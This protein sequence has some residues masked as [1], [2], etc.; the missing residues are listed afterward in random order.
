M[1]IIKFVDD[2]ASQR[3]FWCVDKSSHRTDFQ[4]WKIEKIHKRGKKKGLTAFFLKKLGFGHIIDHTPIFF[5]GNVYKHDILSY[6][7]FFEV[8]QRWKYNFCLKNL[9]WPL[10]F[11]F[12]VKFS[13]IFQIWSLYQI[14]TFLWVG[15]KWFLFL[16]SPPK[17]LYNYM[18]LISEHLYFN[19]NK[20]SLPTSSQTDF[21]ENGCQSQRRETS[22]FPKNMDFENKNAA[23]D[24]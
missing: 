3:Y 7:N 20:N 17:V 21:P 4:N 5:F 16:D 6:P 12:S 9:F 18:S 15:Q 2:C 23:E 10:F 19:G 14:T 13:A 8:L 22:I 24:L 11:A 1:H